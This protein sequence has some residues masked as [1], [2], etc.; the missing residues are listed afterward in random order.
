[1]DD[2][3]DE[4]LL[5]GSLPIL[6]EETLALRDLLGLNLERST[7]TLNPGP[8]TLVQSAGIKDVLFIA[9]DFEG[10][11]CQ[12]ALPDNYQLGISIL[13]TRH[14]QDSIS[15]GLHA[16]QNDDI[17]SETEFQNILQTYNLCHG[18][19]GYCQRARRKLLF[20]NAEVLS[21]EEMNAKI[22]TLMAERDIILVVHS[23]KNELRFL[24]K[25][26]IVIRPLYLLDTQK[27]AQTPLGLLKRSSL[28]GFL[29][30]FEIPFFSKSLHVGGN[31]ANYTL[32]TL[33]MTAVKDAE[34]E[35]GLSMEQLAL[36]EVLR[37]IARAEI[38]EDRIRKSQCVVVQGKGRLARIEAKQ[39]RKVRRA[40]RKLA[41]ETGVE[42][43]LDEE[44]DE[45][46]EDGLFE[47]SSA[48]EEASVKSDTIEDLSQS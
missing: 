8:S 15:K 47:S 28:E 23:G 18:H 10:K 25:L 11:T 13:D 20:G 34:G 17:D 19:P 37:R 22:Q 6:R 24:D 30:T 14:L 39:R 26:E 45:A 31:D 16:T 42:V 3:Q 43:E 36:L 41:R 46:P 27:T 2:I 38:P 40:L 1:M 33:L 12:A 32:R 35:E 7:F 44:V 9:I 29:T 21:A 5:R 48:S 4:E